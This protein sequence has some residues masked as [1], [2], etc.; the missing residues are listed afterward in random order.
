MQHYR[1]H[2]V[3]FS[4]QTGFL[5]ACIFLDTRVHCC[6]VTLKRVTLLH[7]LLFILELLLFRTITPLNPF[8]TKYYI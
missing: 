1:V 2:K 8:R 7:G 5:R 3:V 6:W 4:D